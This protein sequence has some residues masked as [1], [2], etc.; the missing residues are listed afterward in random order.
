MR[1]YTGPYFFGLALERK[2]KLAITGELGEVDFIFLPIFDLEHSP[3]HV[4]VLV[5]CGKSFVQSKR[6]AFRHV[7][8]AIR[9]E[10][11]NSGDVAPS[12]VLSLAREEVASS[13]V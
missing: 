1:L 13:K 4:G 7:G 2:K 5:E 12:T 8:F 11:H 6:V 3:H 10:Y 9:Y